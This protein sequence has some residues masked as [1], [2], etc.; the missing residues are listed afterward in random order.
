VGRQPGGGVHHAADAAERCVG[1]VEGLVVLGGAGH[2][3]VLV[4]E[5]GGVEGA[6]GLGVGA[7]QVGPG[8]RAWFVV[9]LGADGA[10]GLPHPERG[11]GRVGCDGHPAVAGDV[12]G[13]GE[14]GAA[15]G[16]DLG[17]GGV[18][19]LAGQVHG[20]RGGLLG[21]LFRADRGGGVP[22][23]LADVV[24]PELGAGVDERPAHDG[25]VERRGRGDVGGAQVHPARGARRPRIGT[26]G[27][28]E[29]P[30]GCG[31][32]PGQPGSTRPGTPLVR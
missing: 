24:V 12:E 32:D 18:G 27:H 22:V 14:Q 9:D 10:A 23:D 16:G 13:F 29:P 21:V 2:R 8:Q 25:A 7:P 20:P 17:G 5:H 28:G 6:G 4:A 26:S 1:E 30:G 15:V 19:V 11:A 31:C 3:L